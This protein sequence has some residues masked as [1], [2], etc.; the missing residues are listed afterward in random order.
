M[1]VGARF[2]IDTVADTIF[3]VSAKN[4]NEQQ[5]V[6]IGS[7]TGGTF[8]LTFDGQ[9]TGNIDFDATS[10]EVQTALEALSNIASGDVVVTGSGPWIVEFQGT[11]EGT[12]V[13]LMTIDGTNLTGGSGED[14]TLLHAGG[15]TWELTFSP[16]LDGG[17]L[18]ANDDVITFLP[19]QI[20]VKIG[21]GNLTWTEAREMTYV[22]DRG[23]LDTVRQGNDVPL[24][25]SLEFMFESVTQGTNEAVTPVDALK[26]VGGAA[27]WTSSSTD[28]C[29]PY[30]VDILVVHTPPCGNVDSETIVFEDFRYESLEYDLQAG[31]IAVSGQANVTDAV[32]TRS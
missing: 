25:V 18:P 23:S 29:E 3:T 26:G 1:P 19:I 10:G 32:I 9:E 2:T 20:D 5:E 30:A 24:Q 6:T 15:T 17:D 12:D 8:T 21:E 13:A 27:D 16:A 28:T 22:L 14:V 4:D 31:T 7:Q 11:Y